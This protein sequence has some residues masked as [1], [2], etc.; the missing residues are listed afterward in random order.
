MH[1][2]K[3]ADARRTSTASPFCERHSVSA[4]TNRERLKE[5]K[6][7]ESP[8]YSYMVEVEEFKFLTNAVRAKGFCFH[9]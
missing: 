9:V 8:L 5:R 7:K 4:A 6:D 1:L 3:T 2:K